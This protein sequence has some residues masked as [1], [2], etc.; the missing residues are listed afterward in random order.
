MTMYDCDWC[1]GTGGDYDGYYACEKCGGSGVQYEEEE[2]A[3]ED[4]E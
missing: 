1:G 4:V 3:L 2:V